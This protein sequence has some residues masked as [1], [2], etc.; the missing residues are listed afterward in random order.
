MSLIL[1]RRLRL[2]NE[3]NREIVEISMRH[4]CYSSLP[5]T[6]RVLTLERRN[7][8][9]HQ[10]KRS[11]QDLLESLVVLVSVINQ[12]FPR[13][14]Y[15]ATDRD[16]SIIICGFCYFNKTDGKLKL[17]H[18][19]VNPLISRVNIENSKYRERE[20]HSNVSLVTT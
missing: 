18:P 11:F 3:N 8:S 20:R 2:T 1:L 9:P 17:S 10:T 16:R 14:R 6:T 13:Y 19:S 15:F 4:D 5:S 12:I 7:L